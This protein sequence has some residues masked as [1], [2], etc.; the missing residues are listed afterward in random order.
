MSFPMYYAHDG[1]APPPRT[2]AAHAT[3]FPDG[4]FPTGDGKT[5]VLGLQN[6]R[7]WSVFC[8]QVLLQPALAH[9]AR[10]TTH[11]MPATRRAPRHIIT[12]TFPAL[13]AAQVV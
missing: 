9:D 2:G 10:R 6:E 4:P 8:E 7:E 3:I 1:A 5:V 11:A 12:D 13:T